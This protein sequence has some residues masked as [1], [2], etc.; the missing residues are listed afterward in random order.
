MNIIL[1]VIK[2]I[3]GLKFG[4]AI[5][6]G[7]GVIFGGSIIKNILGGSFSVTKLL[8]GFNLF[9]GG[10][11]GKLIYYGVILILA[12]GLYHQLTRATTNYD[13][14]YKNNINHNQDVLVDQ[15]VGTNNACDVNL[16]FGLIKIGCKQ[17][18]ITKIVNNNPV[19]EKCNSTKVDV[20]PINKG[21]IK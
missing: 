7:V 5:F 21:K 11:Q 12:F 9:A 1:T 20:K 16:F 13:T 19:C 3:L 6:L 8:G 14:D 17:L 10:V 2:F 15:R 18:P 4:W